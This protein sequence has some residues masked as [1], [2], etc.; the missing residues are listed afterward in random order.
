MRGKLLVLAAGLTAGVLAKILFNKDAKKIGKCPHCGLK[1]RNI[2]IEE[3][4]NI[5]QEAP[6]WTSPDFGI[7][8]IVQ[9]P[10]CNQF[11]YARLSRSSILFG[12]RNWE[13][14]SDP[15]PNTEGNGK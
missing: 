8:K 9:C 3:W 10:K 4:K 6:N 11:I 12:N 1:V 2:D 14:I 7:N 15:S 5:E 13:I